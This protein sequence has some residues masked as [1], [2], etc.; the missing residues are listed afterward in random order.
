[1]DG[2]PMHEISIAESLVELIEDEARSRGF[3]RVKQIGVKIGALGHV[4][5]DALRFC[6][7]AASHGTI[8]EGARLDLEIVAGKGWCSK[9]AQAVPIADRYELC[10]GCGQAHVEL[11]AGDELRLAELEVE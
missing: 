9:C 5:P 7:D 4:E 1:M 2:G 6:F 11:I 8:A 10:P 3:Q